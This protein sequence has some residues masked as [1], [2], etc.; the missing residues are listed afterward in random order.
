ML[1]S[2]TPHAQ[3]SHCI[4]TKSKHPKYIGIIQQ[5]PDGFD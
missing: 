3:D 5:K 1:Q 4:W 2:S